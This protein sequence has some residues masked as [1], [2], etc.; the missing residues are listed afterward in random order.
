MFLKVSEFKLPSHLTLQEEELWS[1]CGPGAPQPTCSAFQHM[2]ATPSVLCG[3]AGCT[4][5]E[6]VRKAELGL[7][8]D[9]QDQ[10]CIL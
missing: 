8:E 7:R 6:L 5:L 10:S 9:P 3:P 2:P 4:P 1:S